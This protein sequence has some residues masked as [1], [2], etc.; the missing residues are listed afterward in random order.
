[1]STDIE[2]YTDTPT[3]Q[4]ER[5][6]KI[7]SRKIKKTMTLPDPRHPVPE[8]ERKVYDTVFV[9]YD[10]TKIIFGKLKGKNHYSQAERMGKLL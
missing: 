3:Q 1:M 6:M 4:K 9:C 2:Y 8:P 7:K 5:L 10:D